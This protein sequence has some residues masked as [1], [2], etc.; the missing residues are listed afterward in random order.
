[1]LR[2]G[3]VYDTVY[4]IA[5]MDVHGK[6]LNVLGPVDDEEAIKAAIPGIV[7]LLH[8]RV[9]IVHNRLQGRG[10]TVKEIL[11]TLNIETVAGK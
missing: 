8:V 5:S 9:M 1:M 3:K 7:S 11:R 10:T 6:T 4:R 2:L